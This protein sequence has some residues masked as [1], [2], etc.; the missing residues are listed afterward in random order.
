MSVAGAGGNG[1]NH[2]DIVL[3]Y[4]ICVIIVALAAFLIFGCSTTKQTNG[5]KPHK[6]VERW[7]W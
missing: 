3:E 6:Q 7:Q 1:R 2:W 5:C 4:V